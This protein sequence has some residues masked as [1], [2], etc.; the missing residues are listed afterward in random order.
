VTSAFGHLVARP[1][2]GRTLSSGPDSTFVVE[3]ALDDGA[4]V[5]QPIAPPHRHLDEDEAWYVLEGRLVIRLA[6]EEIEIAAGEAVL[7][8]R[9]VGHTFWNPGPGPARYLLLMGPR[10]ARLVDAL[11]DGTARDRAATASLFLEYG[12]ELL[13]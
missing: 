9:G 2:S 5:G 6:A 8:P 11:H 7:G 10:T 4:W 13:P 1:L 12:V 3:E